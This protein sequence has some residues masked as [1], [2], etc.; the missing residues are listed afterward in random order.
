MR[1]SRSSR[2]QRHRAVAR[3][4]AGL[5]FA[6]ATTGCGLS[7][8]E[9]TVPIPQEELPGD[10]RETTTT[11]TT[12][13]IPATVPPSAPTTAPDLSIATTDPEAQTV[14]DLYYPRIGVS[15]EMYLFRAE[16]GPT[17]DLDNLIDALTNPGPEAGAL[18]LRTAIAEGLILDHELN[19]GVLE[20]DLDAEQYSRM[21]EYKKLQAI[22]QMVLS[23]SSYVPP[24]QGGIGQVSFSVDGEAT[25]V[26]IPNEGTSNRGEGVAFEDFASLIRELDQQLQN[27][28]TAPFNPGGT[29]APNSSASTAT[30]APQAQ[31]TAAP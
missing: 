12:T 26:N 4:V 7:L 16:L 2:T 9:Q 27:P 5:V 20:V 10:I 24:G 30:T 15:D 6:I 23:F 13:T 22:P 17:G 19:R 3:T 28:T 14:V 29:P 21:P 1:L 11:T 8:D 25:S 18:G 31:T